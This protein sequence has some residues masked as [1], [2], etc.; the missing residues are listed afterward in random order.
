M[1]AQSRGRADDIDPADQWVLNPHT[2]NYE[3]RLDQSA[4]ESPVAART[5]T[6]EDSGRRRTGSPDG[7][8]REVPGQ[9]SR[10]AS[11]SGGRGAEATATAG[12]RK[13][14]SPKARRKKALMW[15]GGVTAFLVVSAS[16][17]A[18]LLYERFN[19]NIDTVDIGDAGN[20]D[21]LS[22][23]PMN[24]LII[25]TDKRTGKG[26][27][28][29][30]DKGS[31]GH[32]DTNILFHVSEDRTNATAMSIPRDLMTDI[33]DCETKQP[34]G[35][36]K[37]IPGT[38]NV[39]FNVSL[40]Q[41]G[42][43]PGCTMR[44]VEAITGVKPDHFMMVDFNAVK[45]LTTAVGGVKVCMAKPIDDPKSH[46]KLPKGESRV[47]GEDALALLRTRHSFGNESDLDRIK[48]QQQFLGSMI[49]EMKSSDTLT[50]PTKLFKL[51]DAAT[52]ALTVD[53]GIGSAKK[54]MTLAQEIG[55]VDTKNITFVTMP[56]IDNP[57][58]PTPIT[59]V[60]APQKGEQLFAMMRSDTSLTE[61]KQKEKAAKSK[62]A[63]LL[64]GP[65]A[66][67][68]DVR[69]DVLNGG[70]IAGAAGATVTWLQN[71]QGVLKSTNKANAPE[72]IKK[73]TLAYAPNQADQARALAEMMGLPATAMKPGTADAEG[74]QAM[75]LTLGADFKGAGIPITGPAKAPEDIQRASADKAVCAQ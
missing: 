49:R 64:K 63:A 41:E 17:G 21:V 3:L 33:P 14:K 15:T 53:Q 37:V 59:V 42:R 60:V 10:R 73:T 40:G 51:A 54:L 58:E 2:G 56:V 69:V 5:T 19:S 7:P 57:A 67:P 68:A 47:E 74:L 23:G 4:G 36:E 45:E 27:E 44:T 39:R 52:N 6:A 1:D 13:R 22:D 16:L 75:V 70:E 72:K 32:A 30:G 66:A 71:E 61:V 11:Q 55:K 12:R 46:L 43:D 26:N 34:D 20:K 62:Q 8:R 35:S 38:P 9:R 24:I 65:K 50:N 25:G 28:G 31:E 18:Y 29:Y 48:V